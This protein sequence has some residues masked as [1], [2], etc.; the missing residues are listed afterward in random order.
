MR[1]RNSYGK[2][3]FQFPRVLDH[4]AKLWSFPTFDK[5]LREFGAALEGKVG[6]FIVLDTLGLQI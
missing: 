3:G 4:M 5:G 2:E 1:T 6:N